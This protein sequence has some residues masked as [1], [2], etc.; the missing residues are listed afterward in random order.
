[1]AKAKNIGVDVQPPK[2]ECNDEKCP[3][4]G[5]LKVRGR[6]LTG[7]I[8]A[9]DVHHSATI[10]I[11]RT[12]KIPK[13]ERFEKLRSRFRVHNPSCIEAT[14]GDK[15]IVSECRPIS[16]TKKFV[17]IQKVGEDIDFKQ[18]QEGMEES[19]KPKRSKEL[20]EDKKEESVAEE[21]QQESDNDEEDLE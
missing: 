10:E 17:V 6:I 4:H 11:E 15:V 13:Y 18:K 9:T 19:K 12:R 14:I 16:K 21:K 5:S 1:M 2:K 20:K 3:F 7:T 8:T